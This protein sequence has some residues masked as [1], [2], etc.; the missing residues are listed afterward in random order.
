MIDSNLSDTL[1]MVLELFCYSG[2][3]LSFSEKI[4]QGSIQA[5]EPIRL[6]KLTN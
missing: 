3:S 6:I 5:F 4:C 2:L 1:K